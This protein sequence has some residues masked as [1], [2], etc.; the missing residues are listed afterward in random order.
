MSGSVCERGTRFMFGLP[1]MVDTVPSRPTRRTT[2]LLPV[3]VPSTTMSVPVLWSMCMSTT[4]CRP[5][6]VP[7][8]SP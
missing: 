1:A 5:A 8:P 3:C 2:Q 6:E 4:D 7:T